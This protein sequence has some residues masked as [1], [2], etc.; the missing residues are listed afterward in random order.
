MRIDTLDYANELIKKYGKEEAYNLATW[1]LY[2]LNLENY[3][4]W[5]TYSR[6]DIESNLGR[7]PTAEEFDEMQDNLADCFEYIRPE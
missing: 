1:I 3:C 2:Q 6:H 5:Q 4:I 7:K